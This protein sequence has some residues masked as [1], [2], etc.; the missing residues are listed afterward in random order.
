MKRTTETR[1]MIAIAIYLLGACT[2]EGYSQ[3]TTLNLIHPGNRDWAIGWHAV[4]SRYENMFSP[5]FNIKIE[6]KTDEIQV[7]IS[8]DGEFAWWAADQKVIINEQEYQSWQVSIL[9]KIDDKWSIN[10]AM[11]ADLQPKH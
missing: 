3:D 7:Y 5:E 4:K 2:N 9:Q 10:L 8:P 6:L 1:L 11:D